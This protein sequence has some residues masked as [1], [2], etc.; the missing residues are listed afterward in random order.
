MNY[1]LTVLISIL[2]F[3]LFAHAHGP[4]PQKAK[5]S[6]AINAPVEQVWNAVK[7][8]DG[9]A[10]WHPD[11]KASKGDGKHESGGMRTVTLQND[12]E[13]TDELDYYSDKDHEYSYRLK[14]ENIK[15]L[16]V[17]SYSVELQV[18]P[19]QDASNSTVTLKS[20]FYRGDTGNTPPEDLTDEAAVKAMNAFFKN[21]LNGLKKKME[22]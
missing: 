20:R 1:P 10:S 5:E 2:L 17:S 18:S 15:A 12:A 21:G 11:V 3:P 22:P 16:P 14:I 7:Q 8:F 9:I 19:G 6:I 13:L 4:T